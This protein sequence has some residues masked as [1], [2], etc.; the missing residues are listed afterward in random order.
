MSCSHAPGA[1][2]C[3]RAAI[4]AFL[5]DRLQAKLDKLPLDDAKRSEL[6][7]KYQRGPWLNDA[8]RRVKHIQVVT[9][10]LKAMHPRARGTNLYIKPTELPSLSE[11]GSHALGN[12]FVVDVTGDAGAL[13]VYKLLKIESGGRSLLQALLDDDQAA[14]QAL[15]DDPSEAKTLRE[16]LI[17]IVAERDGGPASHGYAKQLYWLV[18]DNADDDA[19]YHLISPLHPTSLAQV[20]YEEVQDA[21]FGDSNKLARQAYRDG[22]MYEGAY[23]D[24]RD[25]AIQ[26]LGSTKPQ[27][28]SQLTSERGGNNYLLSSLPP[29]WKAQRNFLPVHTTSIFARS[30]GARRSVRAA[31]H[32][33]QEH[34]SSSRPNNM[35]FRDRTNRLRERIVD[36]LVIYAGELLLQPAGWTREPCFDTLAEEEKLWLDPLRAE[37]PEEGDFLQ[38]WLVMDWPAQIGIGF[39]NWLNGQ[40]QDKLTRV[41][42]E[43]AREWRKK[44]LG[45][46][47]SWVQHLRDL[48]DRLGA[49]HYI[50]FRKTHGE[51]TE[52]E[53]A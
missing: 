38:R 39:G 1:S 17:S 11:V 12:H 42:F 16:A 49:P 18:G 35:H 37:L 15:A 13:D 32:R 30:F 44:L 27:I 22:S 52:H 29:I 51:L 45:E 48:R 3:F 33:L 43:E 23:R 21:R 6:I 20:I 7:A 41:S 40:L 5:P 28:V 4:D 8:A 19:Q 26:K 25:L 14:L 9:H 46:G 53:R 34:L 31:V 50:P 36:E 2:D 10:S 24:Y 47:S